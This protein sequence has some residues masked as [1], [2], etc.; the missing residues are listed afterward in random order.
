MFLELV[1]PSSNQLACESKHQFLSRFCSTFIPSDIA[2]FLLSEGTGAEIAN[3]EPPLASAAVAADVS[4]CNSCSSSSRRCWLQNTCRRWKSWQLHGL[5]RADPAWMCSM[6]AP[7]RVSAAIAVSSYRTRSSFILKRNVLTR[8]YSLA[9]F[10]DVCIFCIL[11]VVSTL[12]CPLTGYCKSLGKT[13]RIWPS[14][15]SNSW[16]SHFSRQQRMV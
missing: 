8:I 4:V 12:I 10:G 16:Q 2:N 15:W 3:V 13:S 6:S 7:R 5:V 11:R 1:S 14:L 9:R